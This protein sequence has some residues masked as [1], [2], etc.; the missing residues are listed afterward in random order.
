MKKI[1]A[2]LAATLLMSSAA[3]AAQ[4][5]VVLVPNGHISGKVKNAGITSIYADVVT[6]NFAMNPD[7]VYFPSPIFSGERGYYD[8]YLYPGD[9]VTAYYDMNEYGDV[10]EVNFYNRGTPYNFSN[11]EKIEISVYG[12]NWDTTCEVDS[13][14]D[15]RLS[16]WATSF[17]DCW[18]DVYCMKGKSSKSKGKALAH[19]QSLAKKNTKPAI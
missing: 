17:D 18:N 11:F 2:A 4:R 19:S 9:S 3:I 1:F 7:L 6:T 8:L 14:G 5:E 12:G 10:C 16:S 13:K 15:L